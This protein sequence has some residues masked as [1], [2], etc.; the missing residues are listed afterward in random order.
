MAFAIKSQTLA[1]SLFGRGRNIYLSEKHFWIMIGAAAT[2]HFMVLL[3]LEWWPDDEVT[4][5]PVRALNIKLG[6][7]N[8]WQPST[9]API[10]TPK[11]APSPMGAQLKPRVPEPQPLPKT[12]APPPPAPE[13]VVEKPIVT[14]PASKIEPASKAPSPDVS[15]KPKPVEPKVQI[16]QDNKGAKHIKIGET[17]PKGNVPAQTNLPKFNKTVEPKAIAAPSVPVQTAPLAAPKAMQEPRQYVRAGNSPSANAPAGE[18]VPE[19]EANGDMSAKEIKAK[20]EQKISQWLAKH[21]HYPAAARMLGQHGKPVL[22]IR[23]DRQGNLKFSSVEQSS[24][25]RL[26]DDAAIDMAKRANPLPTPPANYPGD[27]LLEFLIP[28]TF[29]LQ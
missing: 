3:A 6:G 18:G 11:Q 1:A 17:K 5:I 2:L 10:A 27:K 15:F 7:G 23:I 4:E 13:P 22:R 25:F 21:K 28:V 24:G 20:Y 19:G 12:I 26:I 8:G 14:P 16:K 29:E 9:P